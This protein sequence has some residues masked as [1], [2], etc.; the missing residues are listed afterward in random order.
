MLPRLPLVENSADLAIRQ[1][2]QATGRAAP[3]LRKLSQPNGVVVHIDTGATVDYEVVKMRFPRKGER[4]TISYNH[5]I[6]I[7]NIPT[8]PTNMW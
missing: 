5:Q 6:T 4:H 8:K 1:S 2:R 7:E 3:P